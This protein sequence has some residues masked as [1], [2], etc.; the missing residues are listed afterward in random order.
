[1]GQ[2]CL[3]SYS[4]ITPYSLTNDPGVAQQASRI[5]I[6]SRRISVHVSESLPILPHT[7]HTTQHD[8]KI[9]TYSIYTGRNDDQSKTGVHRNVINTPVKL[10]GDKQY[11]D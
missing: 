10:Q 7:S 5:E 3:F 8:L 11:S 6:A 9:Q 4:F 1:M 2:I